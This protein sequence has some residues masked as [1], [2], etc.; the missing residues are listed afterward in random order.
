MSNSI[1]DAQYSENINCQFAETLYQKAISDRYG[2]QFCCETLKTDSEI[3]KELLDLNNIMD[4]QY[5]IV[6]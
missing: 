6:V 1:K 3:K 5:T 4:K 2:I